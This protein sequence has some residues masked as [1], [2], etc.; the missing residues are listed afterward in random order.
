MMKTQKPKVSE[1][2]DSSFS[3]DAQDLILYATLKNVLSAK[4]ASFHEKDQSIETQNNGM[5][6]FINFINRTYSSS[7]LMCVVSY[8]A[9]SDQYAV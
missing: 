7:I 9:Q 2:G 8:R 4:Y 3:L 1:Q 6:R 5:E